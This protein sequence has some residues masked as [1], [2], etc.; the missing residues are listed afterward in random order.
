MHFEVHTRCRR[1]I[2][3]VLIGGANPHGTLLSTTH[4]CRRACTCQK[5]AVFA[6]DEDAA[7]RVAAC[8]IMSAT[9]AGNGIAVC[10]T[11]LGSLDLIT[12]LIHRRCDRIEE[13]I[14][15]IDGLTRSD[16]AGKAGSR[17]SVPASPGRGMHTSSCGALS[18]SR[19]SAL[20]RLRCACCSCDKSPA[21]T[22]SRTS[23]RCRRSSRAPPAAV[24][25]GCRDFRHCDAWTVDLGLAQAARAHAVQT[26]LRRANSPSEG[27]QWQALLNWVRSAWDS[28]RRVRT[29]QTGHSV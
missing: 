19:C 15:K 3:W 2:G 22:G 18:N 23:S 5:A 4:I 11:A 8:L 21:S 24:Q 29:C 9:V 12:S 25:L 14:D 20:K 16:R 6:K 13:L 26:A 27:A 10:G 28:A 7:R 17:F 1:F